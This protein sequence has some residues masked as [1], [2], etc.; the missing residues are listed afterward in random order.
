MT[1]YPSFLKKSAAPVL[2]LFALTVLWPSM[3][4]FASF[5]RA[6]DAEAQELECESCSETIT[7]NASREF[8]PTVWNDDEL[9]MCSPVTVT[10]PEYLPV[11]EGN[12][13]RGR[14][15]LSFSE[16]GTGDLITCTYQAASLLDPTP[17]HPLEIL[18]GSK[19]SIFLGCRRNNEHT[20]GLAF[21][22]PDTSYKRGD[23]VTT[24]YLKLHIHSG[25][26]KVNGE[27]QDLVAVEL[28]LENQMMCPVL[29]ESPLFWAE[30]DTTEIKVSWKEVEGADGYRVYRSS[31][32][33]TYT[34]IYDGTDLMYVDSVAV[35]DSWYY[36]VTAYNGAGETTMAVDPKYAATLDIVIDDDAMEEDFNA[37]GSVAETGTWGHYD[38]NTSGA[39][40][41]L[42]FTTG[43]DNH[44]VPGAFADQTYS[45]TTDSSLFGYYDVYI[46]YICDSSRGTAYYDIYD[47]A[48]KLNDEPI[49]VD[50]ALKSL[51]GS[52]CGSQSE[53]ASQ[54]YWVKLGT[55]PFDETG[56]VVLVSAEGDNIVADAAGWKL[57]DL[58]VCEEEEELL[59]NGGFEAPI[60][61]T[62]KKWD[63]FADGTP[64]L[65]WTVVWR[66]DVPATYQSNNR[67][68]DALLEVHRG[69]NGWLSYEGEQHVEMS[70]DWFGP[71][72]TVS[73]EPA[74]VYISQE[75]DTIP[76]E[77]Y[78]L[79]LAFSPRPGVGTDEAVI[80]VWWNGALV[81]TISADGTALS[82]TDWVVYDYSFPAT[83]W[84]ATLEIRDVGVPA[85]GQGGFVDA[86]QLSC[87]P[88][89]SSSASSE[90]SSDESSYASSE[91]G[92]DGSASS[93]GYNDSSMSSE[94]S[95]YSSEDS[96]E[97]SDDSSEY[98]SY[99]SDDTCEEDP[100]ADDVMTYLPGKRKNGSD[101]NTDRDDPTAALGGPDVPTAQKFVSL[102]FGGSLTVE[103]YNYIINGDGDDLLIND[104]TYSTNYPLETADV[105]ASQDGS[106][107]EYLGEAQSGNCNCDENAST[108]DLGALEWARYVQIIDTT[109]PDI[110]ATNADGYDVNN[111]EALHSSCEMPES[112]ASSMSSYASSEG[113]QGSSSP[114]EEGSSNSSE[115]D[116]PESLQSLNTDA[117]TDGGG[118]GGAY[119]GGRTNEVGAIT[120]FLINLV[121]GG[122]NGPGNGIA[123]GGFG[124]GNSVPLSEGEQ[125]YICSVRRKISLNNQS[126][127]LWTARRIANLIDRDVD[128]VMDALQDPDLCDDINVSRSTVKEVAVEEK[129]P[130][131]VDSNGI[132]LSQ[133]PV[134]NKCVRG[135]LNSLS[136]I[137]ANPDIDEDG[138]PLTCADYHTQDSWRHPDLGVYFTWNRFSRTLEIPEDYRLFTVPV[139]TAVRQ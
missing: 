2:V 108:F 94:S 88:Y 116:T 12:G 105:Y 60:V 56:K 113:D 8:S 73:G 130:F 100:Y 71:S 53:S 62:A 59:E 14:A 57:F 6:Q 138:R 101:I 139:T 21:G 93:D 34:E 79:S 41:I 96:S 55:F 82:Q 39:E 69:V 74:A 32:D 125:H 95:S 42:S 20:E 63:V 128:F 132:P 48:D 81:D 38:I 10:L 40:Q 123:P 135:T 35:M 68:E 134:W 85:N 90:S 33:T 77:T 61:E 120:N 97:S 83:V 126:I 15:Q 46:N 37:S 13:G 64:G 7:L 117:S 75:I 54:P 133:N 136:D 49:A 19:Y 5:F 131:P 25:A 98:S 121:F 112:S 51:D 28:E 27:D 103:F 43:G 16:E 118:N 119:R 17:D 11:S 44:S 26:H 47:G 91:T 52:A 109:N 1:Y 84:S 70:T 124:G 104:T 102:G 106:T 76:G 89:P 67:P 58:P 50:Q 122:G 3:S 30:E 114:S 24:D 66:D 86:V 110:H 36:K 65:E 80:E 115:D 127:T 45:W 31:D 18:A 87:N 72:S 107:W 99:S 78:D 4:P 23:S 111:L 92:S 137:R 29:P 129:T 22:F 9:N